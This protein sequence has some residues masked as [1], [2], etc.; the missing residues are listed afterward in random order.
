MGSSRRSASGSISDSLSEDL[1][2]KLQATSY[3]MSQR[4]KKN[5]HTRTLGWHLKEIHVTCAPLGKKRTRLKL[6]TKV[7]KEKAY[8]LWRRGLDL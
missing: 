6:Y 1:R 2:R 7:D 4:K 5:W 8:R 3:D